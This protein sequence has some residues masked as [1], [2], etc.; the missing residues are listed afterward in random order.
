MVIGGIIGMLAG[1]LG[2]RFDTVMMQAM[3]VLLSFPSLIMG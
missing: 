3:D 2:G 1:Y